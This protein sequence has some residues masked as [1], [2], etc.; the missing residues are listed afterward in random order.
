MSLFL[1]VKRFLVISSFVN[2]QWLMLRY[3]A[4]E[5]N[6]SAPFVLMFS[7]LPVDLEVYQVGMGLWATIN[8]DKFLVIR[9]AKYLLAS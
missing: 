8:M 3:S 1:E 5:I 9:E 4:S 6:S 7:K 2:F